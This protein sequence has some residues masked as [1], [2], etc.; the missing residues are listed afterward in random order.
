MNEVVISSVLLHILLGCFCLVFLSW[1]VV[2][3]QNVILDFRR[4]KRETKKA[5]QDD[6]YHRERMKNLK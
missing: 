5:A 4:D 1:A 2:G 3:I 6:E